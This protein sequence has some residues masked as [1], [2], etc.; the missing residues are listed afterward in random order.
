MVSNSLLSILKVF[1]IVLLSFV[2]P[3][4]E[5]MTHYVFLDIIL[6]VL[7]YIFVLEDLMGLCVYNS[8]FYFGFG[9]LI[10]VWHRIIIICC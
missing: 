6:V 2:R 8:M 1:E 3:S 4:R 9:L 10:D 7:K 5:L